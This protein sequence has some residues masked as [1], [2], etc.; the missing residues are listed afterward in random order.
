MAKKLR[1][2]A[3]VR[4]SGD[5]KPEESFKLQTKAIEQAVAL[6]KGRIPKGCWYKGS[7]SAT[8]DDERAIF[9]R[10]LNDCPKP[11]WI[12]SRMLKKKCSCRMLK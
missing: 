1:F 7:E 10:F 12:G 4:V 2:A 8:V 9:D 3:L 5:K 11:I 6:L